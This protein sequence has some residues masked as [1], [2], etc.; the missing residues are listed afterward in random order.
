MKRLILNPRP[1]THRSR[2][3]NISF[4]LTMIFATINPW[5]CFL[6]IQTFS[7]QCTSLFT[8]AH[9]P[10]ASLLVSF[11]FDTWYHYFFPFP[12]TLLYLRFTLPSFFLSFSFLTL[13]CSSTPPHPAPPFSYVS[14]C[15]GLTRPFAILLF[16]SFYSHSSFYLCNY[17]VRDKENVFDTS[18]RTLGTY[19]F[20][21]NTDR[22]AIFRFCITTLVMLVNAAR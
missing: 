13:S 3:N 11:S 16:L 7:S 21:S 5:W 15:R 19:Y 1:H 14:F 2:L 12:L 6:E 17:F 20:P 4:L 22:T 10:F 9:F 8:I 18:I